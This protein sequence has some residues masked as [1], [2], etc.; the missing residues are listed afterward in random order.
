M[1][2]QRVTYFV[3]LWSDYSRQLFS[4]SLY[5]PCWSRAS[6]TYIL[7]IGLTFLHIGHRPWLVIALIK[8]AMRGVSLCWFPW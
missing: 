7:L 5:I 4:C 2:F 6:F 1:V 3:P 8:E